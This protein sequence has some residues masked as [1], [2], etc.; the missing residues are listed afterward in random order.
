MVASTT[1]IKPIITDRFVSLAPLATIAPNTAIPEIA[2]EPDIKGV[3]K[4]GGILLMISNPVNDAKTNTNKAAINAS[5][6]VGCW[7]L[8][9]ALLVG[10][11]ERWSV[12]ALLVGALERWSVG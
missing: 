8:V 12:G 11:L 6:I 2:F 4:V 9:G 5:V 1:A 7:L 3:C 10:A